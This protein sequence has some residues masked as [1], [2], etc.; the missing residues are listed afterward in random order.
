MPQEVQAVDRL[1]LDVAE[2]DVDLRG[3][4]QFERRTGSRRLEHRPDPEPAQDG[5]DQR[6]GEAVVFDDQH[7]EI[8]EL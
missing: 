4:E 2:D 7:G 6:S 1:H 5:E 3:A 8:F